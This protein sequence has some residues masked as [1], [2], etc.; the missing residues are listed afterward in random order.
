MSDGEREESRCP[1]CEGPVTSITVIG[2]DQAIFAPCGHRTPLDP[3]DL[4]GDSQSDHILRF[5]TN[6]KFG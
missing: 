3:V 2:P 1:V 5:P 4:I 6:A